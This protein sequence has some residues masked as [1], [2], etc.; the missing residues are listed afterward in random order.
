LLVVPEVGADGFA[1]PDDVARLNPLEAQAAQQQ[2]VDL[3]CTGCPLAIQSGDETS[4]A[5]YYIR[6]LFESRLTVPVSEIH[7]R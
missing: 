4:L 7:R 3:L 5:S 2:Q 6:Y 1:I